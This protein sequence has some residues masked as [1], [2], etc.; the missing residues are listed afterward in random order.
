MFSRKN[1]ATAPAVPAAPTYAWSRLTSMRQHLEIDVKEFHC[2]VSPRL[3]DQDGARTSCTFQGLIRSPGFEGML[4]LGEV[5]SCR[6][7]DESRMLTDHWKNMPDNVDGYA[8]LSSGPDKVMHG[9]VFGVTLFCKPS[10]V[11]EVVDIFSRG[12]NSPHGAARL[13]FHIS[14]PDFCGQENYW[15]T[16]WRDHWWQVEFWDVHYGAIAEGYRSQ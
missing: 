8:F 12:I 2:T 13:Q 3:R 11:R 1:K 10:V 16:A 6:P 15:D 9:A 5:E 4:A 14:H 7:Q